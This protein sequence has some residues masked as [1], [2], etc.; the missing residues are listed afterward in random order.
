MIHLDRQCPNFPMLRHHSTSGEVQWGYAGAGPAD[1]ALSILH[2]LL[3][4]PAAAPRT[5]EDIAQQ[6]G[7]PVGADLDELD[8]DHESRERLDNQ[9]FDLAEQLPV[10][11]YDGS[12][13]SKRVWVLHQP[14]KEHFLAPL[15]QDRSHTLDVQD[16]HR[17]IAAQPQ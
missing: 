9:Y 5:H 10:R 4:L 8:L 12:Y 3:P 15:D 2:H 6:L 7:M 1:T 16:L 11:L 17:W 13:V 14:F